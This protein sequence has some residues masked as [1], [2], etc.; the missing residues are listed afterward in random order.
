[1]PHKEHRLMPFLKT[2]IV[3]SNDSFTAKD[4]KNARIS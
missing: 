1:M 3:F 2:N 4:A